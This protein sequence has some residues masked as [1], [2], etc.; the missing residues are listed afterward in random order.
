MPRGHR[1]G[2]L[3]LSERAFGVRITIRVRVRIVF[4]KVKGLGNPIY[5][6]EV[7][8]KQHASIIEM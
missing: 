8:T 5:L 3:T 4:V 6:H 2:Y 7:L 1:W